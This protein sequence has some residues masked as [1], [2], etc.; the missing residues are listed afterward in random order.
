MASRRRIFRAPPWPAQTARLALAARGG[1][2]IAVRLQ[3][4]GQAHAGQPP[5]LISW[6][7]APKLQ[8][9]I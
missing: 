8:S 4:A 2:P 9:R 1:G 3:A 6:V 7:L 5:L